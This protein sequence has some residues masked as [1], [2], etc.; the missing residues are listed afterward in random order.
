MLNRT[1]FLNLED[2]CECL[3]LCEC[4]TLNVNVEA[5]FEVGH[6][7]EMSNCGRTT[8]RRRLPRTLPLVHFSFYKLFTGTVEG[9]E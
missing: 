7:C 4:V 8:K 5:D 6:R 2:T 9:S 3:F 1:N